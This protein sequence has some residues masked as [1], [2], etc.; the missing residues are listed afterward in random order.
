[1]TVD[2]SVVVRLMVAEALRGEADFELAGYAQN[3]QVALDKLDDVR[4][5]V[6]VLDVEMPV[7]DGLATLAELR[8]RDRRL[9][10]VMFSTLTSRGASATVDALTLGASDYVKKPS[11]SSKEESLAVLRSELLPKLRALGGK[12][13]DARSPADLP[14]HLAVPKQVSR[15]LGRVGQVDVVVIGIS[16]GGPNALADMLPRLPADLPVP[17]LIVQHMPPLFTAMLAKRL[18]ALSALTVREAQG[19]EQPVAGE[20]WV[21]PG[22][23]H[24]VVTKQGNDVVLAVND[25]PHV[26]SCRPA[27]DP[28]FT[29]A[30]AAYGPRI[31]S[32]VMTGMGKDGLAGCR[33]VAAGGGQV[34]VQDS[35]SSVVWGMPR[36]VAEAGLAEEILPLDRI[37]EEISRRVPARVGIR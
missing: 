29:S 7:L 21:A 25:D 23:R 19:G 3:G 31:L 22:G 32:V 12:R 6:I 26:N 34:I 8:K 33:A 5:D 27:V 13:R 15:S 35:D 36:F 10:V 14:G 18:D 16:T 37:A 20:V 28:L 9:P 11:S 1:M 2:D 4:P 30:V 24:M 17:V